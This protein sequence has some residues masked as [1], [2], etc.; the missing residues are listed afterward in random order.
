MQVTNIYFSKIIKLDNRLRE[1]NF[2]KL[3]NTENNYHVDVTD[4]RGHRIMFTMYPDAENTWHISSPEVPQ[5]I[6]FAQGML[7]ELI[8]SETTTM[9]D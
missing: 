6:Q 2:R 5:W 7:G 9:R 8:E 1:F 4:D 3:P